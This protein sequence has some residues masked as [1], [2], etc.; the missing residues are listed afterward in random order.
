MR[1]MIIRKSDADTEAGVM[2]TEEL[3]SAMMDYHEQ[4]GRDLKILAGDG[5]H[6]SAKGARVK[7]E[8]GKPMV[9]DGPFTETKELIAG[10]SL[11]E[12]DSLAQVLDWAKRWPAI[13]GDA[14]VELEIRQI[15]DPADFGDAFTA[16]L[17]DKARR[18][19]LGA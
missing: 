11:V 8:G 13:C 15:F 19:G 5:L 6:P 7:F 12:A 18:I 2:P 3:I 14:N 4:M 16:E 9:I 17:Q 10:Y 1:F